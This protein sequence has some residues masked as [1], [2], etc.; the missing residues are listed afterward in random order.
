MAAENCDL[1]RGFSALRGC[2]NHSPF[3]DENPKTSTRVVNKKAYELRYNSKIDS[4]LTY[5][6]VLKLVD[7]QAL[8]FGNFASST[9]FN[10]DWSNFYL[11]NVDTLTWSMSDYTLEKWIDA[12]IANLKLNQYAL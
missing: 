6:Q 11:N 1:M 5:D 3:E 9:T 8:G 7:N 10:N 12:Q 2:I 4:Q